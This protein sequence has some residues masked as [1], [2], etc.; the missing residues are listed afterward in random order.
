MEFQVIDR[1]DEGFVYDSRVRPMDPAVAQL[2]RDY[3]MDCE[4]GVFVGT[5]TQFQQAVTEERYTHERIEEVDDLEFEQFDPN[6]GF[7]YDE[8]NFKRELTQAEHAEMEALQRLEEQFGGDLPINFARR[9]QDLECIAGDGGCPCEVCSKE[10]AQRKFDDDV[11]K[12][13]FS[14]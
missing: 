6:V 5:F 3:Q 13:G 8:G 1:A 11:A 7:G 12:F 14:A 10:R 4:H 2:Y 9:L